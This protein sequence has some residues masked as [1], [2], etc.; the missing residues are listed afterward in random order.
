MSS[1]S[2]IA[3]S[4]F[5]ASNENTIALANLN[6]DFALVKYEAPKEFHAVGEKLS[7]RRRDDAEDGQTHKTA[8]R[9][10]ALFEG[11]VPSAPELVKAYG[12]RASEIAR[13]PKINPRGSDNDGPFKAFI[14]ADATSI[15]AAATS[16]APNSGAH[17]PM[18]MH[19]LACMLAR[20]WDADKATSIWVE[21]VHER[22]AEIATRIDTEPQLM[23]AYA[24]TRQE[25]SREQLAGWDASARS[26][27]RSADEAQATKNAQLMLIIKNIS[28]RV[29][30]GRSTYEKVTNAW[31]RA[32]TGMESL[33]I[34][35]SQEASEGYILLALSAWHLYPD[36][37]VLGTQTQRVTFSDPLIRAG[38]AL[39][40]GL[41][42]ATE[43]QGTGMQWSM[44]LS[45][46]LYYGDP[47][48][49]GAQSESQRVS[50]DAIMLNALGAMFSCW[51]LS[52]KEEKGASLFL[53]QIWKFMSEHPLL[54]FDINDH[55]FQWLHCLVKA[56]DIYLE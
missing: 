36:L 55:R 46:L 27:L 35:A 34:G 15:W 21:L 45:H 23:S 12:L 13:L 5:T 4:L 6:F 54:D 18:A 29:S 17:A 16:G 20:F 2:R 7:S 50:I 14:G 32:M 10:G 44:T 3:G 52:E 25:I 9:L 48:K 24:A 38:G 31:R 41:Q 49:V 39:T 53:S 28:L 19:L 11:I 47:V 22:Q 56:A 51:H 42:F 26:W 40:V 43:S 1:I 37:I 30:Q 33:V 8:R